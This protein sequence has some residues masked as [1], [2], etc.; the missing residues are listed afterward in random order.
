ML[1][2]SSS[3]F[4][5]SGISTPLANCKCIDRMLTFERHRARENALE[6]IALC[7]TLELF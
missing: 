4:V 6:A 3:S 7:N 1:E 2:N 5:A